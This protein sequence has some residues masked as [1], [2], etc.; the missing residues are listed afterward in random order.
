M[1]TI[2]STKKLSVFFFFFFVIIASNNLYSQI[3]LVEVNPST[4]RVIIKNFGSTMVDISN[5]WFC[6][7]FGYDQ[8]SA[9]T[10]VNGSLNLVGSATV[11]ISG[12][13]VNLLR[14]SDAD[15]GLY[16]TNSNFGLASNMIDFMQWGDAG[17]GRE[18]VANTAGIWTAG[19]FLT[20][21]GPFVYTGNGNE[22]GVSFWTTG[23]LSVADAFLNTAV[24]IYPNPTDTDLNIKK[25]QNIELN[26]AAIFDITGRLVST[27]NLAQTSSEKAI[28]LSHLSK[29]IY[30]IKITDK[31]GGS[32]SKKFI[33]I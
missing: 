27:S 23:T 2:T 19:D 26:K 15:L 10:V 11:T 24:S 7:L 14:D 28:P 22:N 17:N 1:K 3:R 16:T 30:I 20:G 32:I 31:Q 25:L 12:S 8:L 29:G 33:K 9:L 6:S 4:D 18:S 5:Y 21:S 13:S